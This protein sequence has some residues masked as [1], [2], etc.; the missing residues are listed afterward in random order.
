MKNSLFTAALFAAGS[1]LAS[2]NDF[3]TW[4]Q[5][6]EQTKAQ[7]PE[8]VA[9]R[10]A[11]RELEYGVASASSGF[12]PQIDA[13]ASA[14]SGQSENA[15][16]WFKDENSG[17]SLTL[18]QDLFAGGGNVAKRRQALARLQIG[19]EQYRQ[20]LSDVELRVRLAYVDVL[21]AQDLIDVTRKIE[22]R[23]RDNV[24]LIQLRFDG[25]RENAG[26]LARTKAQLSQAS[27]EVRQAERALVYAL[28]NLA[29][30]L[31]QME[32]ASGVAGSLEARE[33][34]ALAD[35]E[36]LM[37]QTPDYQIAVTQ[38]E[39]SKQGMLVKRSARFP[40][41]SFQAS[42]GLA[43]P[44][45]HEVYDGNWAMKLGASMP[46]FT[47][48]RLSSDV[49]AAKEAIVQ[50]EMGLLN[51]A[52]TLMASLQQRWNGYADA[53]EDAVTQKE[54]YEAEKLRE[55][56]STAKYTQ[57]LLSFEDWDIIE[58]N[59]INQGK[60]QLARRRTAETEEAR[61]K[62]ALGRSMWQT[63]AEGN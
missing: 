60:I 57:G 33:P 51:T 34:T 38:V 14:S 32:P 63:K 15:N 35:L 31:G 22:Q 21:Y 47:G 58:N 17:A 28:R 9:A 50:T 2:T 7:S 41:V 5:C 56:I 59:L 18:T 46:L 27:F 20:T 49:A 43:A 3:L 10:A 30:A 29:S 25:G 54:V 37:Q 11:V 8:L 16:N 39:A 13:S 40:Q 6:I 12:L 1:V 62:N 55:E 23:R 52:N 4:E 45:D 61:W 36:E 24:R 42:A 19:N 53:V 48:N 26:S 44:G